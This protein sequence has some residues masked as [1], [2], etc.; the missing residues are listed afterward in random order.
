ML[1]AGYIYMAFGL[2]GFLLPELYTDLGTWLTRTESVVRGVSPDTPNIVPMF[3][4]EAA[5][6]RSPGSSIKIP[7]LQ[8]PAGYHKRY[9]AQLVAF[10]SAD[11][12]FLVRC[13]Q[14]R[15]LPR[16]NVHTNRPDNEPVG[17]M[18]RKI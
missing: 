3:A 14:S 6:N 5:L 2:N 12:E 1:M 10:P 16:S 17:P 7:S 18:T 11:C 4:Y 8:T 15:L 13:F 9:H